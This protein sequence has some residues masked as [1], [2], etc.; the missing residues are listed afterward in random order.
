MLLKFLHIVLLASIKY[1]VTLPYAMLI[2]LNYGQAIAAVLIGGIGGFLFFYYLS[3]YVNKG[4]ALLW[5]TLC[6]AIPKSYKGRYQKFCE[7]RTM[8]RVKKRFTRK[9]RFI[10]KMR[11]TYGLWGIIFA[12]P[13]L[14]SIP[15]GAFLANKYYSHKK[16]IVLYMIFSIVGWGALLSGLVH[17]FPNVFF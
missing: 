17:L 6:A 1:F 16:H 11:S 14:L 4:I 12:T 3:K 2:G 5:P 7:R 15:L 13:F 9:N 10:I 8:V